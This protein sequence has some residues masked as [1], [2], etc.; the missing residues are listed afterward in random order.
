M[1]VEYNFN[2]K[3]TFE[4]LCVV[5]RHIFAAAH[6][7]ITPACPDFFPVPKAEA[8]PSPI[9]SLCTQSTRAGIEW[10]R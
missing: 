3:A 9:P 6:L 10:R 2:T 4:I 8:R 7:G 1:V 5:D